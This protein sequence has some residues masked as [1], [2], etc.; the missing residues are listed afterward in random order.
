MNQYKSYFLSLTNSKVE[1]IN[2]DFFSV[3]YHINTSQLNRKLLMRFFLLFTCLKQSVV[4]F[5]YK[6]NKQKRDLK[7]Y[8]Y[9]FFI[10]HISCQSSINSYQ[11]KHC[12]V[13]TKDLQNRDI[14][15]GP[16]T[17]CRFKCRFIKQRQWK[18]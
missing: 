17:N 8:R 18:T 9:L 7:I 6:T 14:S 13:L 3:F 10:V 2:T 16:S 1:L 15:A 11:Q 5:L 4:G 12:T